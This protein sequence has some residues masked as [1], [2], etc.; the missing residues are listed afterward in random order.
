MERLVQWIEAKKTMK[1]WRPLK[2]SRLGLVISHLLFADDVFLFAKATKDR[3][4]LIKSS[5]DCF[6]KASSWRVSF[7][8]S[9]VF[10]SLNVSAPLALHLSGRLGIPDTEDLGTYLG[11]QLIHKG[12]STAFF[13]NM[14]Q[15]AESKLARWK[16]RCLSKAGHITLASSVLSSLPVFHM[17]IRKLPSRHSRVLIDSLKDAFRES[18]EKGGGYTQ[19]VEIVFVGQRTMEDLVCERPRTSI[20]LSLQSYYGGFTQRTRIPGWR[21]WS[22]NIGWGLWMILFWTR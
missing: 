16:L 13:Q 20:N 22:L 1:H 4:D 17:Q 18:M 2:D 7:S 12:R 11:C 10:F 3:V 19:S 5:L 9:I 14:L 21:Y 8:K 15:H 6:Y